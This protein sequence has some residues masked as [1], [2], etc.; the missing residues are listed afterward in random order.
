MSAF[1]EKDVKH[2]PN[3]NLFFIDLPSGKR[4]IA[5]YESTKDSHVDLWHTEVPPECRGQGIAGILAE[6]SIKTLAQSH[7]KVLLSCTYLQHFHTKNADKFQEFTNIQRSW[8]SIIHITFAHYQPSTDP[9]FIAPFEFV[10]FTGILTPWICDHDEIIGGRGWCTFHTEKIWQ[11]N[12][13]SSS[14]TF[15]F[16]VWIKK[17]WQG[18]STIT[19]TT[20]HFRNAA[21][22]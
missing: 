20:R 17:H 12:I 6:A 9:V 14:F 15:W 2:D 13:R 11:G 1:T 10:F 22:G 8:I 5:Q 4:A 18:K 7:P 16:L 19:S 3:Q 21:C